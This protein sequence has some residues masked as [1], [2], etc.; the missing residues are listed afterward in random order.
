M[1]VETALRFGHY[2]GTGPEFWLNLQI[3]FDLSQAANA[4]PDIVEI[5][6]L[7]APSATADPYRFGGVTSNCYGERAGGVFAR[8]SM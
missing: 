2:F 1:T 4:A 5:E 7:A 3:M 6:P 8:V